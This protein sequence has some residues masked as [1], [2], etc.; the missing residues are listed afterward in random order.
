MQSPGFFL[1]KR[2]SVSLNPRVAFTLVKLLV[3]IAIIAILAAM[4]LPVL[5]KAEQGSNE[6]LDKRVERMFC[7]SS[8]KVDTSWQPVCN[9]GGDGSC[10]PKRA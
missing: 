6:E 9:N 3:V 10:P 5:A 1:P 2:R 7:D 8:I 4:L